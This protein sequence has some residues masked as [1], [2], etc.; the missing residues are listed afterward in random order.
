DGADVAALLAA[1]ETALVASRGRR[2]SGVSAFDP[3]ISESFRRDFQLLQDLERG[4]ANN[5]LLPHYQPIIDV[6]R[7]EVT[8]AEALVRWLHPQRGLL[9][10]ADFLPLAER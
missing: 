3:S 2:G 10:P 9:M 6:Q 1:A 7:G 8:D 5:E 4:L